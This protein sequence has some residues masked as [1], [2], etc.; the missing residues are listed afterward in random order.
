MILSSRG[1][2]LI[3]WAPHVSDGGDNSHS[4]ETGLTLYLLF[5]FLV[6]RVILSFFSCPESGYRNEVPTSVTYWL[7]FSCI[8]SFFFLF[9][10]TI[11]C[12]LGVMHLFFFHVY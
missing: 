4:I 10:S 5:I 11:F 1:L 6:S 2:G 9:T 12:S 3:I 7:C 8:M